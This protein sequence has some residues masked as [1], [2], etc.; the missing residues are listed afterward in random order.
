MCVLRPPPENCDFEWCPRFFPQL[1][2]LAPL[3]LAPYVL[4]FVKL[5]E[6]PPCPAAELTCSPC[7]LKDVIFFFIFPPWPKNVEVLPTRREHQQGPRP[8]PF[9][10]IATFFYYR[11]ILVRLGSPRY[12]P[13]V[14]YLPGC[15]RASSVPPGNS[16]PD[17]SAC[18]VRC[19]RPA[20]PS[21]PLGFL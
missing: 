20:L 12:L 6:S 17:R 10:K 9:G 16:W 11:R 2:R 5:Q 4:S 13:C 1:H 18:S 15:G 19:L 14:L 8:S 3:G 7:F 21:S